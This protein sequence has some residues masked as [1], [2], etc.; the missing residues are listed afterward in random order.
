MSRIALRTN[1]GTPLLR[2]A[3][4]YHSPGWGRHPFDP[5]PGDRPFQLKDHI[6]ADLRFLEE[7]PYDRFRG[8]PVPRDPPTGT[9]FH[10]SPYVFK[11]GDKLVPHGAPSP[12]G[13]G[14][15]SFY[16]PRNQN[17]QNYVWLSP[18][19]EVAKGWTSWAGPDSHI[20]EVHPGDRPQPWEVNGEQGFVTPSARIIREVT[21][22]INM[23]DRARARDKLKEKKQLQLPERLRPHGVPKPVESGDEEE[24]LYYWPQ[25]ASIITE[26]QALI[27]HTSRGT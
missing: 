16:G 6:P 19:V 4:E 2:Y 9:W 27:E 5:E 15:W 21:A 14:G 22:D 11:P 23:W 1:F 7:R 8:P 10:T 20:Y 12:G 18:S 26:A 24:E 17:R 3:L 25:V 13:E